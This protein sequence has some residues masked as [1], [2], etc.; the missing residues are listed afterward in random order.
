MRISENV[1][2]HVLRNSSAMHVDD[3]EVGSEGNVKTVKV[4]TALT[5][6]Q[7]KIMSIWRPVFA[8]ARMQFRHFCSW[9]MAFWGMAFRTT[10]SLRQTCLECGE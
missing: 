3:D 5:A 8:N 10:A 7:E 2:A 9:G 4:S 6:L 1:T